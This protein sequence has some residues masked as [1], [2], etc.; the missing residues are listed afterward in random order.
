MIALPG[1]NRGQN[2]GCVTEALI[3]TSSSFKIMRNGYLQNKIVWLLFFRH[4]LVISVIN[5]LDS[6][7]DKYYNKYIILNKDIL[8][9]CKLASLISKHI[10]TF[11][12]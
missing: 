7:I 6:W 2:R 12:I 5:R 11:I 3:T 8:S 9:D 10:Y 4:I 1:L